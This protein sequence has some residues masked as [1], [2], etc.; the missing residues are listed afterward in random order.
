MKSPALLLALVAACSGVAAEPVSF[1]RDVAPIL[2]R[3]CLTCHG[4]EKPKGKYRL[5]TFSAL[6]APGGSG[7][8]PIV[9]GAPEESH[10]YKLLVTGD[11]DDRMPQKA[12]ALRQD[13]IQTLRAWIEQGA[14]F[15]GEDREAPLAGLIE[16]EHPAPPA[17]YRIPTPI[18][19]LSFSK[20]GERLFASGYHEIT[21]WNPRDGSLVAR[22]TNAPAR[23]QA[24]DL[25]PD[26]ML[27]A[28]AGGTPGRN[29]EVAIYDLATHAKR[30]TLGRFADIM[31][32]AAFS[33]DGS[34]LISGGS[35]STIHVWEVESQK[36]ILAIQQHADWVTDLAASPDGKLILSGSRD[37]TARTYDLATGE[38]Q[39]T[40]TDHPG[41]IWS[42]LFVREGA[43]VVSAGRDKAIRVWKAEDGGNAHRFEG[44][45]AEVLGLVAAENKMIYAS[46][47]N[48]SVREFDLEKKSLKRTLQAGTD[49]IYSMAV[50][51]TRL[52]VGSHDGRIRI[53]DAD[54]VEPFVFT[55]APGFAD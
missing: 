48:G 52:A 30:A 42:A 3:E 37:K 40:F 18:L 36:E 55:A 45:P 13:Q 4:P 50:H 12:D 21:V 33:P 43:Q 11:E 15:D 22:M 51:G 6:R 8:A 5:D 26:G 29:G 24:L 34:K 1:Q 19:A 27:L 46:L 2:V 53:F 44:Q 14:K 17:E 20:D 41:T 9:A 16:A 49:H 7:H 47:A 23:V 31:L 25:S 10:F 54:R 32:A 28:M 38:L 39:T 35:D